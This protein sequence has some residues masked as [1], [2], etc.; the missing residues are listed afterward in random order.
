MNDAVQNIENHIPSLRHYAAAVSRNEAAADELVQ[1]CLL[2]ALTKGRSC[3]PGTG[4]RAW[5]L[6]ILH[7]LPVNGVRK[8][9]GRLAD[10]LPRRRALPFGAIPAINGEN[11]FTESILPVSAPSR[12]SIR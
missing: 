11:R 3:R 8:A 4:L 5:M 10:R 9:A 1:E 2:R 6:T 12:R 7:N